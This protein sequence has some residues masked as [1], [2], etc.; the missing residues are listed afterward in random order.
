MFQE[1]FGGMK[2][3]GAFMAPVALSITH[4]QDRTSRMASNTVED[5]FTLVYV[6]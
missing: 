2:P 3:R 1:G 5:V 4:C 6:C